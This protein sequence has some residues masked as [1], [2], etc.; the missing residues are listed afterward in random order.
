MIIGAAIGMVNDMDGQ[1]LE[2]AYLMFPCIVK[3]C[4]DGS[5]SKKFF[6]KKVCE[7]KITTYNCIFAGPGSAGTS[8]Y[9]S[10]KKHYP[11]KEKLVP[12]GPKILV[13]EIVEAQTREFVVSSVASER[14]F[15]SLKTI[16]TVSS[17]LFLSLSSFYFE[18][19]SNVN[20]EK[21]MIRPTV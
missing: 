6:K 10:W 2:G 8:S 11:E 20:V 18:Q 13:F 17:F 1:R 9:F 16:L 19:A 7:H 4:R 3:T 12:L 15:F 14:I 5:N 21:Q